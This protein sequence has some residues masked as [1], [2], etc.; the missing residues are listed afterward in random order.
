MLCTVSTVKDSRANIEQLV[1]RNLASGADHMFIF[2]E[3]N[4]DDTYGFLIDHPCVTPVLTDDAY[5][6]DSRPDELTSRQLVNANLVNCLLSP[7]ESVG[8]LVHLDGDECLDIDKERLFGLDAAI[9]CVRLAVLEAVSSDQPAAHPSLDVQYFKKKLKR[10]Q[11]ERLT[12]LGAIAAPHNRHYFFGYLI[13][14]AAV[15]PGLDLNMGIH[16]ASWKNG[17][18]IE[19]LKAEPFNV[20][21]YDSV[22]SDEFVRKW[23]AHLSGGATKFRPERQVVAVAIAAVLNEQSLDEAAKKRRLTEIYTRH[24]EDPVDLLLELGLLVR[25]PTDRHEY[26]PTPFTD[27]DAKAVDGLLRRLLAVD[28]AMFHPESGPDSSLA[29]MREVRRGFGRFHRA[30][31]TRI[32]AAIERA[33]SELRRHDHPAPTPS[34]GR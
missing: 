16:R 3:I 31:A 4:A 8:W 11:L 15:R 13:G 21:H 22:S 23:E 32:D 33:V 30:T 25:P 14:K 5:W 12:E 34:P 1:Q 7:L 29:V 20:L 18:G 6:R 27:R 10:E 26:E 28:K 19:H 9:R 17:Q 24:I 2:L